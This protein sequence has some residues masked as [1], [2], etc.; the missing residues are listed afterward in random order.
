M[1][2][3]REERL[4][5]RAIEQTLKVTKAMNLISTSKLRKSRKLLADTEPYFYRIQKSMFDII[6]KTKNISS[7]FFRKKESSK[8]LSAIVVITSDKGLAGGYN[9]NVFRKVN[10][11]CKEIENPVLILIGA[12]GYKYFAHSHLVILEN[13]SFQSKVPTVEYAGEI[14]N[15]LVSQYLWGIFDEIH[16]IYTHMF[17]TVKTQ[18]IVNQVIPLDKEKLQKDLFEI[19]GEKRVDLEFEFMPSAP[20]VFDSLVPQYIKGLVYGCMIEAYTSEQ[21]ARMSAMDEASKNAEDMLDTLQISY[22][23]TRQAGITQ[24]ITE[25]TGGTSALED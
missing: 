12:M 10:E 22:N 15:Y 19:G 6:S 5:M 7:E 1:A 11:F 14:T 16:I 13:F 20:A 25:I 18:P 21:S 8:S 23:R 3:L 17:N 9:A 2:N 24:E 4:R